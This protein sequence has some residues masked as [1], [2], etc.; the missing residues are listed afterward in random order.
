[1]R[2]LDYLQFFSQET[3]SAPRPQS[4]LH[5]FIDSWLVTWEK[6]RETEWKILKGLGCFSRTL[7]FNSKLLPV[8]QHVSMN[9]KSSHKALGEH[10]YGGAKTEA[11]DCLLGV[12]QSWLQ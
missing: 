10:S 5:E 8:H 1:M 12:E 11:R 7:R 4:H 9:P 6:E 2:T 3:L